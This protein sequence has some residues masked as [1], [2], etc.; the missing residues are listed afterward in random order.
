M[1][2]HVTVVTEHDHSRLRDLLNSVNLEDKAGKTTGRFSEHEVQV[3][4]NLPVI[5]GLTEVVLMN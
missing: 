1:M 2:V 3:K 5:F 4:K